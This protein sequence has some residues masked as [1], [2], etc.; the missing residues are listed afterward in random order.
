MVKIKDSWLNA[1]EENKHIFRTNA[2]SFGYIF[3]DI[4]W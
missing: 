3:L 2:N 1:T 4:R